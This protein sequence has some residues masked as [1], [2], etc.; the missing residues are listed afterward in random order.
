MSNIK[1]LARPI[2]KENENGR[3]GFY[4]ISPHSFRSLCFKY[5]TDPLHG[6]DNNY[7]VANFF[8]DEASMHTFAYHV[9]DEMM[10][11]TVEY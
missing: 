3:R 8:G 2:L 10:S 6:S 5:R 7:Y 4:G 11:G 1:I 9:F